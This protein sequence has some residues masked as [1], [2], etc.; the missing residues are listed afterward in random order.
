MEAKKAEDERKRKEAEEASLPEEERIIIQ[1][2]K[3]ADELKAQ[4]N[5]FYKKR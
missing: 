4:G 2:K 5:N 3:D 1:N